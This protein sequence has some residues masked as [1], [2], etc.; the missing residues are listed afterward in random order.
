MQDASVIITYSIITDV[1]DWIGVEVVLCSWN[2]ILVVDTNELVTYSVT[3]CMVEADCVQKFMGCD[4]HRGASGI[5]LKV[6]QLRTSDSANV[7]PTGNKIWFKLPQKL[8]QLKLYSPSRRTIGDPHVIPFE[9]PPHK[10]NASHGGNVCHRIQNIC[11][12]NGSWKRF[13]FE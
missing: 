9:G 11:H 13:K 5:G 4:T 7:G 10:S 8:S 2:Y 1:I 6:Q 12:V 3:L